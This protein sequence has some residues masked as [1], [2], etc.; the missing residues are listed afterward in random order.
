MSDCL[1]RKLKLRTEENTRCARS[2]EGRAGRRG[3][4]LVVARASWSA[5]KT[6]KTHGAEICTQESVELGP[7]G[8]RAYPQRNYRN[9][10][11]VTQKISVS[12]G[13]CLLFYLRA[14][15]ATR[16]AR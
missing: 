14:S 13:S 6:D 3:L 5:R 4:T 10:D 9:N 2:A 11:I 7:Y 15:S 12:F 16:S 1:H 8:F